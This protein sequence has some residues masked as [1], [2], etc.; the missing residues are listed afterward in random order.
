MKPLRFLR[1][2]LVACAT[3]SLFVPA[4]LIAADKGSNQPTDVQ[5]TEDH[6]LVGQY[7][8]AEGQPLAEQPLA[9]QRG[10][11]LVAETNT[12]SQGRFQFRD[13]N[14]GLFQLRS[15]DQ[16]I[17][18]RCWTPGAAPPKAAK[19]LLV[20]GQQDVS[21]GQHPFPEIFK[22]PLLIAALIAGAVAIPIAIHNSGDNNNGS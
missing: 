19:R 7:V 6:Q 21:R 13:L 15:L 5:L 2:V 4:G 17:A 3:W 9:L 12:D 16:I 18:C 22:N 10:S 20:V 1:A 8:D 11:R 14:G